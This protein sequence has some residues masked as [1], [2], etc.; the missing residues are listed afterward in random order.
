MPTASMD[1]PASLDTVAT[2]AS[3]LPVEVIL[4]KHLSMGHNVYF[5][6]VNFVCLCLQKTLPTLPLLVPVIVLQ[7]CWTLLCWYIRE[8]QSLTYHTNYIHHLCRG[9]LS[10]LKLP[11]PGGIFTCLE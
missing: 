5:H 11:I 2:G 6:H 3:T 1:S 8:H 9:L 4:H 7:L 10:S